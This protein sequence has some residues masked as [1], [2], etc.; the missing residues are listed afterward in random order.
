MTRIT[1]A[2]V[3][4]EEDQGRISLLTGGVERL[5]IAQDG[6]VNLAGALVMASVAGASATTGTF[7][8]VAGTAA[9]SGSTWTGNSGTRAY[10]VHDIV[11]ALKAAGILPA[12]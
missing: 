7:A 3:S 10:T 2:K 11:S 9:L 8:A 6:K 4:A 5:G 1:G 12:S